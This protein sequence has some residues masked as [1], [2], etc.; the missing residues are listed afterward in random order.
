MVSSLILPAASALLL[1]A[2]ALAEETTS[3]VP[4]FTPPPAHY[5]SDLS[6]RGLTPNGKVSKFGVSGH[7]QTLPGVHDFL[8]LVPPTPLAHGAVFSTKPLEAEEWM[9][10]VAFRVHGPP[11]IGL[12]ETMEDGTQKRL[13]KG[14]RGLAFWYS[15]TANPGPITITDE[16]GVSVAPPPPPSPALP[17]DPTDPDVSL[18]GYRTSF[19]GL[20]VIFDT[21]P[22]QPL[23]ARSDRKT[24]DPSEQT[25]AHHGLGAGG[26][27]VSGVLDDGSGGKWL[28]PSGRE[29]KIDDEASYLNSAIG[30]CEAAFR[31]ANGL[32]W[33]RISY[34]NHTIRVDLDLS[35]HTTLAKAGRDYAH[36]CFHLPGL[37]LAPGSYVG[38][39]GLASA[40]TEPDTIDVYAGEPVATDGSDDAPEVQQAEPLEGTSEEAS[41]TLAHEIFL[42]QAKMVEAIDSLSRKVDY[43]SRLVRPLHN[44]NAVAKGGVDGTAAAPAGGAAGGLGEA[45]L[46]A[47]LAHIEVRL[48][49]LTSKIP[50]SAAPAQAKDDKETFTHL[51]Q[52]QDRLM[53]E[54]QSFGRKLEGSNLTF[55]L[56]PSLDSS[57]PTQSAHTAS[58]STLTSRT[59][60]S[61]SLLKSLGAT[62]DEVSAHAQKGTSVLV[63]VGGVLA[64]VAWLAVQLRNRRSG[65]GG[66]GGGLGLWDGRKMI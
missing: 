51:V 61:L 58:L 11:I 21:S 3:S 54:L 29:L 48:T 52:L 18:F 36:N 57:P 50:A 24:W 37:T 1:A 23:Y 56:A 30:E 22:T 47:Q 49:E 44:A 16:K 28:E 53:V 8:R 5:N 12:G 65:R 6:F 63:W 14:G 43:L 60:E 62:L 64:F 40:Y 17:S 7:A 38:L 26:G 59:G 45:K 34:V 10:E 42:S 31:N 55:L 9:V 66:G 25:D 4:D 15:K 13:H 32:L 35:P 39:S 20:G 27:V 41:T 33:A 46:A 19:D 2:S